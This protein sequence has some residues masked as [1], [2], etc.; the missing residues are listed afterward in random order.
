MSGAKCY[1]KRAFTLIELLVVIAIIALLIGILLPALG[2]ARNTARS[3]VCRGNMRG[4]AQFQT[5]YALDNREFVSSA[6]TNLAPYFWSGA[7][8]AL[9]PDDLHFNT[10]P[11]TPT[12]N[13]D[14][15]SPILGDAGLSPNRAARTAQLFDDWGCAAATN[16]NDFLFRI[17]S[18]DDRDDFNEIL[19]SRGF[20]QVSYLAPTSMYYLHPTKTVEVSGG[21][22]RIWKADSNQP[23]EKPRGH[24]ARLDK[25]GIQLSMKVMFADGTRFLDSRD[26][27]DFDP[28]VAPSHFSSFY[29]NNPVI[30]GSTAYGRR[31]FTTSVLTPGNQLLSFRHPNSSI[32]A[33]YFDGHIDGMLQAEAYTNPDPWWPS[34]SVWNG[35]NAT[36]EAKAFMERRKGS[37]DAAKVN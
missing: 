18:V 31:P 6:T 17:S 10:T 15:M 13:L 3:I 20:K 9:D 7:S 28:D 5:I 26:G 1:G 4:I 36:E 23:A 33:A 22:V 35:T 11:T 34:G 21:G 32:N 25:M 30:E 37:R 19:G 8:G 24:S 16:Y 2:Q 27:L 29:D 12:T 14:W